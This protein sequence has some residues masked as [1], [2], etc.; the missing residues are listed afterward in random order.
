[1]RAD[2]TMQTPAAVSSCNHHRSY[3][4]A[5][6]VDRGKFKTAFMG[7]SAM[8]ALRRAATSQGQRAAKVVRKH[9]DSWRQTLISDLKW[10]VSPI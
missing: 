1:M 5:Y 7:L 3:N 4:V 2:A 9:L 8:T 6:V 10:V